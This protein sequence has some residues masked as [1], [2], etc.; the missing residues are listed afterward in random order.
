MTT[1]TQTSSGQLVLW[2]VGDLS[3]LLR[4]SRSSVYN[5]VRERQL[6]E[7]VRIGKSMRWDQADVLIWLGE[8]KGSSS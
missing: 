8:Q 7:P 4:I 1:P 6:P 2:T 3:E 5:L